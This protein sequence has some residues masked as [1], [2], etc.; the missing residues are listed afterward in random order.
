MRLLQAGLCRVIV[1]LAASPELIQTIQGRLCALSYLT[2]TFQPSML[3]SRQLNV[4]L[5]ALHG[6]LVYNCINAQIT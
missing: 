5:E 3:S 4:E 6:C 1:L 2:A